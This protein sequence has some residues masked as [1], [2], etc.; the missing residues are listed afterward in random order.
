MALIKCVDCGQKISDAAPSCPSC[1]R[2]K[3]AAAPV[4]DKNAP[5]ATRGILSLLF[6]LFFIGA[7]VST[8]NSSNSSSSAASSNPTPPPPP[9]PDSPATLNDAKA[10][11]AKYEIPANS[12]CGVE[13]DDY[14]RSIAKY[15]FKWDDTGFL[16]SK[17]DKYL[18]NVVSPGV[19]TTVSHKAKL[20]NG[21]GAYQHIELFCDY[22]TQAKKVLRFR[23]VGGNA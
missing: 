7:V 12:S 11:D 9:A 23:F 18:V 2:P 20:Q 1:G 17:F 16:E 19:L 14:L 5:S 8:C 13:A 15:D 4:A 6:V 3:T 21:F 22:D 10:L